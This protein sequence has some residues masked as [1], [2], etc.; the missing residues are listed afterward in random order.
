[1]RCRHCD[2]EVGL[3][4]VDLGSSPPSNAYLDTADL[5]RPEAWFPLRV[6]VCEA[7]W[8][9]QTE[10]FADADA[11]FHSDYAYFSGVSST[12]VDHCRRFVDVATSRFG[13][14]ERSRVVEVACNDGTLLSQFR[15]HGVSC[16][17]VEP[18]ERAAAV[19]RAGG[20]VVHEVFLGPETAETLRSE[21]VE[22]DLLVANN[23][24]AHVPDIAGFA[25]GCRR[26][27]A[28]G[29]V[30]TF[31][32]PHLVELIDG[33]LFD[34]I[35]HEHFSYL[36]LC[37]VER[38][39]GSAGLTVFDV[40]RLP[41]HGGSLRVYA[42]AVEAGDRP[43]GVMVDEVLRD[44]RSRGVEEA[45]YYAAFQEST[46]RIKNDLLAFLVEEARSGRRVAGYGAAAKGNTLLNYAGIRGD[47]VRYVVDNNPAKQGTFLPG[48]RIPV[49]AEE[50]LLEDRPDRVLV[51]PWNLRD[52]VVRRLEAVGFPGEAVV[53]AVPTLTIG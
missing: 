6:K 13:L 3:D 43:R 49:V 53:T 52:E 7:C 38:V 17:G 23:V 31:E 20:L 2:A 9:V 40:D 39:L 42:S 50:V 22:A 37:A 51:L 24:L 47:L 48:S 5:D 15:D 19:A 46:D 14:D 33:A 12:W 16:V 41:T 25:E 1:V 29:G 27:L 44:E 10:D 26:L 45:S 28:P 21:G 11:L 34:T 8:L 35:Y 32:F 18:T 30:A 4:L 36:S